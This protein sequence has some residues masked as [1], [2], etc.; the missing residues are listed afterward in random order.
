MGILH[1]MFLRYRF[2]LAVCSSDFDPRCA[3]CNVCTPAMGLLRPDL[4]VM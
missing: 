3:R 1:V 2:M 4:L